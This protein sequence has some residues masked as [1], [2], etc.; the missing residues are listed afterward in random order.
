MPAS[1]NIKTALTHA[2]TDIDALFGV[3]HAKA[4][5]ALV[6]AYLQAAAL[7]E[8]DKTLVEAIENLVEISSKF[9]LL[10]RLL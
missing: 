10:K 9:N 2:K 6:G 4:N 5:P 3:G 8:I 7:H 1:I